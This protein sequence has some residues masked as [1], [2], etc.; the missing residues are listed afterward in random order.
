[1]ILLENDREGSKWKSQNLL[2][3]AICALRIQNPAC[4]V[5]TQLGVIS[6]TN[7]MGYLG[8]TQGLFNLQRAWSKI[9]CKYPRR[10][11]Q[12]LV[13]YCIFAP[14]LMKSAGRYL[15]G[16]EF[17]SKTIHLGRYEMSQ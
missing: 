16:V 2:R 1:M 7:H 14:I 9:S 4:I 17:F 11:N 8:I 15:D 6:K 3:Q 13:R 5:L 10:K 12:N